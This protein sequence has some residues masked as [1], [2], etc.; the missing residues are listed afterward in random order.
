MLKNKRAIIITCGLIASLLLPD[1][2]SAASL[3]QAGVRLG[4]LGISAT[5]GNGV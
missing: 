4:R 3:N 5:S 1:L 2:A